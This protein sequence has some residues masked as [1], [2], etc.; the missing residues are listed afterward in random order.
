MLTIRCSRSVLSASQVDASQKI[1]DI[2]ENMAATLSATHADTSRSIQEK[3]DNINSTQISM[4]Q[5]QLQQ[6]LEALT[7]LPVAAVG[8]TKLSQKLDQMELG[9]QN[10]V[11]YS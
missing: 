11:N 3:L 5:A 10:T 2:L 6:I 7:A 4:G 9:M 8:V 1:Q